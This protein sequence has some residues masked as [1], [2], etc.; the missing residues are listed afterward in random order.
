MKIA[1]LFGPISAGA[2]PFDFS[3]IQD[4]PRGLTG[5]DGAF[6]GYASAMARRGHDVRMFVQHQRGVTQWENCTVYPYEE[7]RLVDS[8]YEAAFAEN[9]IAALSDVSPR[10]VRVVHM[11]ANDFNYVHERDHRA[12]DLY[13]INGESTRHLER[14]RAFAEEQGARAPWVVLPNGCRVSDYA[15]GLEKEPGL[16]IYASSPDRGLHVALEQFARI[17]SR[18]PEAHLRVFYHGLED[19]VARAEQMEGAGH[20][21]DREHG[22]RARIVRDLIAQPGV[23]RVGSVSRRR[24]AEEYARAMCVAFPVDTV[25]WTE[26]FACAVCEGCASGA[27][28]VVTS[29][30]AIGEIYEGACPMVRV[31]DSNRRFA[32]HP[33]LAEQWGDLVVKALTDDD[34]RAEWVSRGGVFA[35]NH[36]YDVLAVRLEQAVYDGRVRKG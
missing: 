29:C 36:D 31:S 25:G 28:P 9:D 5:T 30:D 8:S 10:A 1:F 17:R 24:L 32:D 26:G 14:M 13:A 15:L 27:I 20:W 3:R 6:L 23:E 19:W 7:R 11:N 12:V 22:R 21:A 35:M 18:V 4:D 33:E 16:C 2:R 34:F